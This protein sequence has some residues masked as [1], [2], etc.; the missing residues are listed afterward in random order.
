VHLAFLDE[1]GL[2]LQPVRRRT[3]APCGRTPV[4]RAWDRHDRL[5]AIA[6]LTVSPSRRHI[7]SYYQWHRRNLRTPEVIAFLRALHQQVRRKIMVIWDRWNVHR[8][9]ARYFQRQRPGWFEFEWLPAYAPE[10]DPVEQEWNHAK[11]SALANYVPDDLADLE[12]GLLLALE[13]QRSRQDRLRSY[14][15]FAKLRL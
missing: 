15:R 7:G 1:S 8:S 3:W 10:L 14:F 2:R 5:S 4:Q 6:A 12:V 11:Y 9:A 13:E